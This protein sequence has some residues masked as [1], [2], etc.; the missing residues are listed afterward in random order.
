MSSNR[1]ILIV[2]DDYDIRET[3]Q[4]ILS[5]EGYIV[6]TASNGKE[7]ID[8]LQSTTIQP[9]LVLL[10]MM[11]PVMSGKEFLEIVMNDSKLSTTPIYVYSAN[12]DTL[13]IK[14]TKGFLKK[15][16]S[17]EEILK[18]VQTYCG[19]DISEMN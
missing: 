2:E 1:T 7:G 16:V 17:Y 5:S 18:L 13:P 14:G 3:L 6:L 19:D 4:M 12:G 10:D 9:R 8:L 15:P 11:M